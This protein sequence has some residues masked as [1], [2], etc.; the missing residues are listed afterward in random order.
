MNE[1]ANVSSGSFIEVVKEPVD[2]SMLEDGIFLLPH[3]KDNEKLLFAS[4]STPV[5]KLLNQNNLKI[6]FSVN[7]VEN[8]REQR[9]GD[10]YGPIIFYG[11]SIISQNPQCIDIS[12][13]IIANYLSDYFK[14][15]V[16]NKNAKL[17]VIKEVTKSTKY[18]RVNYDGPIEGLKEIPEMLNSEE[19][20]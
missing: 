15:G 12:L 7:Q 2:L 4:T 1:K 16:G 11:A 10:W 20:K 14:G 6:S 19:S 9:G 8:F 17:V 3:G 18:I 5:H 13:G